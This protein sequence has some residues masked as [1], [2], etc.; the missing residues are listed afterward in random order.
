MEPNRKEG[1][2]HILR[3]HK[4]WKPETLEENNNNKFLLSECKVLGSVN[5]MMNF[6]DFPYLE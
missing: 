3:C 5:K 6:L 2:V 4:G 1:L